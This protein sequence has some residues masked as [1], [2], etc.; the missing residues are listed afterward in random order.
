MPEL[1]LNDQN[2]EAEVI[3]SDVPV[4]VDFWAP[5]CGPCKMQGP[6]LEE[7][8]KDFEGKAV[9]IAKVNV[10][11][12]PQSASRFQIMSI[13]TLMVFKAGRPVDQ[14]MGVQDKKTLTD[15]LNKLIG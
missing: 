14:M 2:F 9:K 5:W 8:A 4:L 7:V 13:P 12:A 3:K 11:E 15:K 1:N 10:D 6:I